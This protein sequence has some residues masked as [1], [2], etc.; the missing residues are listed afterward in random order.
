[1]LFLSLENGDS[2]LVIQPDGTTG[3]ITRTPNGIAFHM[4]DDVRILRSELVFGFGEALPDDPDSWVADVKTRIEP[5]LEKYWDA[6]VIRAANEYDVRKTPASRMKWFQRS[7]VTGQPQYAVGVTN[8]DGETNYAWELFPGRRP[9][10][11]G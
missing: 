9:R 10:R 1:M 11:I 5:H 6:M 3:H 2:C 7:L 8:E 4:D